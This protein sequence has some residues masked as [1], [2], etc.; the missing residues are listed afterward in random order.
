MPAAIARRLLLEAVAA[1]APGDERVVER[2]DRARRGSRSGCSGPRPRRACGRPSRRTAAA[3]IRCRATALAFDLSTM[4]LH[5]RWPLFEV[6]ESTWLP[7]GVEGEREV[8]AV[9]DP[10]VAVEAALEV[11]RLASRAGRRAPGPSRPRAPAGRRAPSRRRRSPGAR[12]S[13]AGSRAGGRR[14][15]RSSPRSPSSTGSRGPVSSLRRWYA[16]V[17]VALQVGVVVDPVERRARLVLELADQLAVAGPALVLV[18]Q[19]HVERRRVDGAVVRRV[20]PLLEG[21]HL[22]VAHLVQDPARVLVAE[23]VEARRPASRRARAASS[24]RAPG[25]NGSACR[26]VKMLSRP[27]MVMNHGSPAAGRLV[28]GRRSAAR[29]AAPRG[30]RGC[31]GTSRLQRVPVAL[32]AAARRRATARGSRSMLG[33]ACFACALVLRRATSCRRRRALGASRRR[34]VVHSP[35]GSTCDAERQAVLVERRTAAVAEI[36]GLAHERSRA[37]SRARA[38][39]RSTRVEYS[40]FFCRASLTSKRSAKSQPASMRTS[41]STGFVVVVEDRQLLVE[42]VA[43]GA[44]ADHR[45]LGVDVDGAGARARGRS[46]SRSTAGRRPRAG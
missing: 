27:N 25:V 38:G 20:R 7:S 2:P 6:S 19:H 44:L 32:E 36:A 29:S 13:R 26:L 1:Q 17:A 40:P 43:D 39:R 8:L 18:E 46:A 11:G 35:C 14:G 4:P 34:S 12:R 45:Q 9:L 21:R 5:S 28:P 3:P 37:R 15:T 10:E 31:A 16:D 22:A 33:R 42:A 23:V 41:R 30:R 24:R